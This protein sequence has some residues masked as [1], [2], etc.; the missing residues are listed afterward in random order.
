MYAKGV[1]CLGG[2]IRDMRSD[3]NSTVLC[4]PRRDGP[5]GWR[6]LCQDVKARAAQSALVKSAQKRL[7]IHE[8]T[9]AHVDEMTVATQEIED[10]LPNNVAGA[11]E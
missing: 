9:S 11:V 7:F 3:H 8:A 10:L 5:S 6:F 1:D 4:K 2:E